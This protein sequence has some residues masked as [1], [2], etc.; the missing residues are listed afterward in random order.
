M[1]KIKPVKALGAYRDIYVGD[2]VWFVVGRGRIVLA[3]VLE[4]FAVDRPVIKKRN[5]KCS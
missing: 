1:K 5:K 2:K 4:I 3:R